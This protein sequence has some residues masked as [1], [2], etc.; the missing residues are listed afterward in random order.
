MRNRDLWNRAG[1]A[2]GLALTIALFTG[3]ASARTAT[4]VKLNPAHH[5]SAR[6][7]AAIA[8]DPA[9]QNIVLFGGYDG[10]SYLNDTWIFNGTDWVQV[11]TSTAPS[12]RT[13]SAMSYDRTL[14]KMVMFGGYNGNNYLG[15]TWVWDG[16][17]QTWTQQSPSTMPTA[18]TLPMLFTDPLNGRAEMVGGFDGQFY[19]N[20]TWQ[21]KNGNWVNLNPATILWARGAA[22]VAN[23]Y[24]RK[25][26][27]IFGGLA[28][29]N[30]VNTWI[31]DGTNWT[32]E[33]PATQPD[34]T[35]YS[36]AAYDPHIQS[37]INFSGGSG[38]NETWAWNGSD[39]VSVNAQSPPPATDSMG[40]AYDFA[41]DQWIMF[42]GE[43][44]G[45]FVSD[46][47]QLQIQ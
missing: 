34:W 24:H 9:A 21:W 7:N 4:W 20:T 36:G 29:L 28:D 27:V 8:Y 6:V 5:P 30:P 45:T 39:W 11:S 46:T 1:R 10:T 25:Q 3:L 41:T 17:A 15:D 19:Q 14:K 2:V 18:V 47:Y 44:T 43:T 35:Y 40:I 12:V 23:D 42:G 33:S 32:M 38:T 16:V 22:V 31:W 37:V 13:A 26:V